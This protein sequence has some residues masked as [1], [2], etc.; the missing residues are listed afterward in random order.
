MSIEEEE[1]EGK[2]VVKH[3]NCCLYCGAGSA[4]FSCWLSHLLLLTNRYFFISPNSFH[5]RGHA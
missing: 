5:L 4:A 3:V 1:A 2:K